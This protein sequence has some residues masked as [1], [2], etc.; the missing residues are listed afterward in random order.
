MTGMVVAASRPYSHHDAGDDS[1][2]L[3]PV[4]MAWLVVLDLWASTDESRPVG[5]VGDDTSGRS[6]VIALMQR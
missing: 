3:Q 4:A 6:M 2:Q 1:G 5:L